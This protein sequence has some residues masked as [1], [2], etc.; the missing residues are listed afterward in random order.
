MARTLGIGVLAGAISGLVVGG[1]GGRLFMFV[2]AELNPE[3][4]GV[5]TDDGVPIGQFTLSGTLNLLVITTVIGVIGG[6]VF[7][8]LRGLRFGPRW[9]RVLSMPVGATIVVGSMLVH[10]D[11][12]DF[13]L[14]QPVELGVAMTLAVP[15][16][17][18]LL[19]ACLADRWLGDERRRLAGLPTSC[20]GSRERRSPCSPCS[21]SSTWC[22]R[23]TRSSTRSSSTERSPTA[24]ARPRLADR[25]AV[26]R[27]VHERLAPDRRCRSDGTASPPARTRRATARSSR[28]RR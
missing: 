20:R 5:R 9:F 17:Y 19:V 27:A 23:S 15:F 24:V 7:L 3:D 13:T 21:P 2:L 12:V 18:T 25:A 8:A 28:S 14:L 16:L 10:S 22:R 4:S 11:G 1:L 26:G 6:L